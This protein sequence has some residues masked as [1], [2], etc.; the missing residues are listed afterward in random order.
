MEARCVANLGD[1]NW[2]DYGGCIVYTDDHMELIEEAIEDGETELWTVW[3]IDI[4]RLKLVDGHLVDL[5]YE[6]DWGAASVHDVWFARYIDS[7]A[8]ISDRSAEDLR[9]GFCS[10]NVRVR[11]DAYLCMTHEV[12]A[13]ELGSAST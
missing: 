11:A 7:A 4:D 1:V 3:H 10:S 6:A 12:G 5:S 8:T 13:Y 9:N 2:L